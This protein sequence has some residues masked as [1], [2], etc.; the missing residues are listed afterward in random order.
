MKPIREIHGPIPA[1]LTGAPG[2]MG[3]WLRQLR[4]LVSARGLY[5]W[6]E[7]GR[8]KYT[9]GTVILEGPRGE[10][11]AIFDMY[12]YVQAVGGTRLLAWSVEIP[13]GSG[14]VASGHV[15]RFRTIDIDALEPL[16]DVEGSCS[17]FDT[18]EERVLTVGGIVGETTV[19]ARLSEG[20]HHHSFLSPCKCSKSC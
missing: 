11:L 18:G 16:P 4:Q 1:C 14:M 13:K 20:A 17:A 10:A 3:F 7:A 8:G 9:S 2:P 19:P 6:R 12:C 5:A 15:V